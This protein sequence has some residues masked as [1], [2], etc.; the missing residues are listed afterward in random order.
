M[1]SALKVEST[2]LVPELKLVHR[3]DKL[4]IYNLLGTIRCCRRLTSFGNT[5]TLK[6]GTLRLIQQIMGQWQREVDLRI[7]WMVDVCVESRVGRERQSGVTR[8][9][10]WL[11]KKEIKVVDGINIICRTKRIRRSGIELVEKDG[12]ITK[13][14]ITR[15]SSYKKREGNWCCAC[16]ESACSRGGLLLFDRLLSRKYQGVQALG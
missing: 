1:C 13:T 16:A 3:L 8:F 9:V 10:V 14:G 5:L 6:W 12:F 15:Y 11:A 4:G 2:R 7:S